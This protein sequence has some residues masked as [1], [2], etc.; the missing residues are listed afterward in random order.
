VKVLFLTHEPLI[1]AIAGPSIRVWELAHLLA[2]QQTVTIGTP[3]KNPRQSSKLRVT[4]FADGALPALLREHDIVIA[5]GYLVRNYPIIR[6]L[7]RYLVMDIYG[8]FILE[9]LHM[10]G[11]LDVRQRVNIHQYGLDVVLE[12]LEVADFMM[13]A[14]E[15]QRDYW[16]GALTM[17]NRINPY[18]WAA[19]P[20][21]RSLV[22][23]VP[24]GLRSDPPEPTGHA[25]KGV[26]PGI[27][28]TDVVALWGGG[29]WNWFDPLTPIRA[30]ARLEDDLPSLKLVFMGTHHPNLANPRMAMTRRAQ[31][32]AQELGLLNRSVFFHEG[33][34]PYEQRVNFLCDSDMALSTHSEQVE[35]RFSFRTRFLDYLWANL[36]IVATA[37]DV[38]CDEAVAIGAGI[39]V[40]DGDVDGVA[41]ALRLVATDRGRRQQMRE[42]SRELA[43]RYTWEQVAKPLV[44]YCANPQSAPDLAYHDLRYPRIKPANTLQLAAASYRLEG[45]PGV[46]KR[47]RKRLRREMARLRAHLPGVLNAGGNSKA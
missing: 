23:V 25:L 32:L 38:L 11:E 40:K 47:A 45:I 27:E 22:D 41:G 18:T 44:A 34:V 9:T 37:G 17:A 1:D 15:R 39:A 46:T 2:K 20:T 42:R 7:A 21:L 24:F 16:L 13:C 8:P 29:I 36:P 26:V 19:D 4:C 35:T 6:K 14:S 28:P 30:I 10:Y 31:D 5:I 43:A 33:W 12:Q 3:N